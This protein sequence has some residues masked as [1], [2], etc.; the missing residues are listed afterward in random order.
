MNMKHAHYIRT[1]AQEGSIT[2]AAR[3]LMVSQPTLS[4]IL[5][6]VEQE[7]GLPV[8][9][10]KTNPIRL[11]Y[12]GER[13]LQTAELI[14]DACDRLTSQLKQIKSEDSG[15]LRLGISIQRATQILPY[16]F[17][18][19]LSKYPNVSI[20][21][22]EEGSA[23]LE[24]LVAQGHVDLALAAVEATNPDL[25]YQLIETEVIGIIAGQKT[26]LAQT[27][28]SGTHILLVDALRDSFVSV[29][30]GHSIRVIQDKLFHAN[31]A[32]PEILLETESIEIAKRVALETGACTLCSN[33]YVDQTVRDKGGFYP[34][35]DYANFRHFYACYPKGEYLPKY[36]QELIRIV[37]SVLNNEK[38]KSFPE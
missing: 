38:K 17:P 28:P 7:L 16:A 6:H 30:P 15:R 19:F 18:W 24:E 33:I 20:T 11:T 27:H 37:S 9:Y 21:L 8:F 13:Y 35:K 14:D 22:V 10:R 5:R 34:L 4:Q 23:R 1:I 2:A 29:K 36:A 26:H 31:R 12:A 32:Q 25:T 3:K